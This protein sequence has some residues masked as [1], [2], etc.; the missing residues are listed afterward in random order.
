ML[1]HI[2]KK[3]AAMVDSISK[4]YRTEQEVRKDDQR[5]LKSISG[6]AHETPGFQVLEDEGFVS[7]WDKDNKGDKKIDEDITPLVTDEDDEIVGVTSTKKAIRKSVNHI[8]HQNFNSSEFKEAAD[9]HRDLY[10][11]TTTL[12]ERQKEQKIIEYY[13]QKSVDLEVIDRES[14]FKSDDDYNLEELVEDYSFLTKSEDFDQELEKG[15]L[16]RIY[17]Y[18]PK[19][20]GFV[21]QESFSDSLQELKDFHKSKSSL[22]SLKESLEKSKNSVFL[23]EVYTQYLEKSNLFET[24]YNLK[25]DSE[26][27]GEKFKVVVGTILKS[28]DDQIAEDQ[29][30][31]LEKSGDEEEL[32]ANLIIRDQFQKSKIEDNLEKGGEGSRGGKIIGHTKSG[33]P[34]YEDKKAHDYKGFSYEDHADAGK[35]HKVKTTEGSDFTKRVKHSYHTVDHENASKDPNK[36]QEVPSKIQKEEEKLHHALSFIPKE[37]HKDIK[38]IIRTESPSDAKYSILEYL[39]DYDRHHELGENLRGH[40]KRIYN[41]FKKQD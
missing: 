30:S 15:I 41:H 21:P 20:E 23:K 10:S 38:E 29:I 33:K 3:R 1:E 17:E 18:L 27:A 31:R 6:D 22:D 32:I 12:N 11:L 40:A 4:S 26:E 14:L 5:I 2:L 9:L 34:V 8:D 25:H 28:I 19:V 13:L 39:N 24:K 7:D 35:I 37:Q 36:V 16:T